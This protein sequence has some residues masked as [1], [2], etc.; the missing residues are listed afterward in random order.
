[1]SAVFVVVRGGVVVRWSVGCLD[2]GGGWWGE[3]SEVLDAGSRAKNASGGQRDASGAS[4]SCDQLNWRA[5]GLRALGQFRVR[6]EWLVAEAS[7]VCG[8]RPERGAM[9]SHSQWNPQ[10]AA[11]AVHAQNGNIH[12][13][14]P[15]FTGP[16]QA[17]AFLTPP[18]TQPTAS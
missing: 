9:Q 10:S 11:A 13:S 2:V 8:A 14:P 5:T 7:L 6:G 12:P 16:S 3:G 4:G 1:M 18:S 15:F 17:A